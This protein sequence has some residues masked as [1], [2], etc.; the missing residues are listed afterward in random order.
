MNKT[1]KSILQILI[2][3]IFLL[4][5]ILL[6]VF[7]KIQ[8][9]MGLFILGVIISF[10]LGRIYCGWICPINTVMNGIT[11][12]KNK[13]HI[14]NLKIPVFLA[15][16][17]VRYLVFGL[18]VAVFIFTIISHKKLPVLPA[19]FVIGILFTFFFPEELWHRYLCP[20]G[21]LMSFPASKAKHA[22][23]INQDQC[24]HCGTCLHECPSKAVAKIDDQE[25]IIKSDCLVCMKCVKKCNQ[26]AISIKRY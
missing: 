15:K 25:K 10:L 26:N 16:P 22:M 3:V 6:I 11:W 12:V 5:F 20:Y 18:F 8:L 14:K 2:Q 17:W 7:G 21:T 4:L 19:L 23:F 1:M 9:W 24:N 13:L